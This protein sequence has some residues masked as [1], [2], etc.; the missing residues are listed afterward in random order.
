MVFAALLLLL[1]GPQVRNGSALTDPV[2]T[3]ATVA[4]EKSATRDLP[5]APDP[6]RQPDDA[7]GAPVVSS[8][9]TTARAVPA[10]ELAAPAAI[11]IPRSAPLGIPDAPPK[12]A[13][14]RTYESSRQRKIWYGLAAAGHSAAAFDAW[15]TRRAITGGYGTEANPLLRP[16]AHSGALYVATQV[17]PA[18]MDYLGRKMMTNRRPWVRKIWWLPQTAGASVSF[19]AGA[20]NMTLQH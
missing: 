4:T 16:F 1:P 5:S 18:F 12:P 14:L 13:F 20:H 2:E 15:S 10:T 3:V 11:I 19:A 6:K 9:D 17:S 7:S 8:T